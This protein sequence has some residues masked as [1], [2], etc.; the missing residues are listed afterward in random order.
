MRLISSGP[1]ADRR[2]EHRWRGSRWI[3]AYFVVIPGGKHVP[4][5]LLSTAPRDR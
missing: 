2:R 4:S 1:P 5:F 3:V